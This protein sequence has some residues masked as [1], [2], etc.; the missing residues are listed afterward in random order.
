MNITVDRQALV[1]ALKTVTPAAPKNPGG[2]SVLNG[3][4]LVGDGR[5]LTLTCTSLDLTI[6]TTVDAEAD[7]AA[8][9]PAAL[10]AR[11]VASMAGERCAITADDTTITVESGDTVAELRP[12]PITDW[13]KLAHDGGDRFEISAEAWARISRIAPMASRDTARPKI[14][15]IFL[16]GQHASATDSYRAGM[17][18]L[19]DVDLPDALIPSTEM[20]IVLHATTGP[21]AVRIADRYAAFTADGTT[22]VSRLIPEDFPDVSKFEHDG[23]HTLTF[24]R[25]DLEQVLR[26]MSLF[27]DEDR[28][29]RMVI[30]RDG[31]KARL[32]CVD[33][34]LGAIHDVVSCGGDF[35]GEVRFNPRFVA[36]LVAANVGDTIAL[37]LKSERHPAVC[38]SEGVLQ[39]LMPVAK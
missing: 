4:H 30:S 13:P 11:V 25:G 27:A 19:D 8:V 17:V 3:V 10:L 39:I 6:T 26:R 38:R 37:Q 16:S 23:P 22:W 9:A 15:T 2:L 34:E 21:V 33:K 18:D 14:C 7:G 36:D 24:E 31:D 29:G 1:K 12:L 5:Q 32:R 20:G 28:G 35:Q